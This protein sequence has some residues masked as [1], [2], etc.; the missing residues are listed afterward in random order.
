MGEVTE[1]IEKKCAWHIAVESVL[2]MLLLKSG[3]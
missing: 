3:L 1:E 2:T